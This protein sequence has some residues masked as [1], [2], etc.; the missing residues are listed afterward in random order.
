M[1]KILSLVLVGVLS[2]SLIVG[3]SREFDSTEYSNGSKYLLGFG[4]T[5]DKETDDKKKAEAVAKK[6]S[7]NKTKEKK[8]V[9]SIVMKGQKT[10]KYGVVH[11]MTFKLPSTL[12][13]TFFSKLI[14]TTPKTSPKLTQSKNVYLT[15]DDCKNGTLTPKPNYQYS[16]IIYSN[17]N[18]SQSKYAGSVASYKVGATEKVFKNFKGAKDIPTIAKTWID[19][20]S[21]FRYAQKTVTSYTNPA[22]NISKWKVNGKYNIDCSTLSGLIMRGHTYSSSPYAKS[23]KKLGKNTKYSWA[24]ELPRT[25]AEQARYCVQKG[26][27]LN[28]IDTTDFSNVPPGAL[29]FYDKDNKLLNRFMAV[30]HVA[31]CVGKDS[32]GVNR[33]IESTTDSNGGIRYKAIKDN[34]PDKIL[35][36]ALPQK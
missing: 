15:G 5:T 27:V 23:T 13:Q 14:F 19:N 10:Y 7:S 21:K 28:G 9:K 8:I 24:F 4:D 30:S 25:A 36:I 18:T 34:A 11:D 31:I 20:K 32:N 16:I 12:T 17:P 1:K 29:I 35:F 26:W 33:L 3:C 2:L 22:A 6:L